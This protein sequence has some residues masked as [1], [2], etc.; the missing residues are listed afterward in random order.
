MRLDHY[1]SHNIYSDSYVI[2]QFCI[3]LQSFDEA[4]IFYI[5]QSESNFRNETF[6]STSY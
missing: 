3:H 4:L 2:G 5:I 1:L 6:V